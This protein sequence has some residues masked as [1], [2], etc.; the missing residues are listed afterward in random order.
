M[1]DTGHS[2]FTFLSQEYDVSFPGVSVT[3]MKNWG[4]GRYIACSYFTTSVWF[5]VSS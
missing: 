5:H 3:E 1:K 2:V 4:L